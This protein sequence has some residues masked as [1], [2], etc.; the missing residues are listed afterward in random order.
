[1][2]MMNMYVL[3]TAEGVYWSHSKVEAIKEGSRRGGGYVD[4]V[5]L[6]Y[7]GSERNLLAS[8]FNKTYT[9]A[10]TE[11]VWDAPSAPKALASEDV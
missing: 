7:S 2:K 10:N 6:Q 9:V 11:R 1:M 4:R 8:V 3:T 5:T